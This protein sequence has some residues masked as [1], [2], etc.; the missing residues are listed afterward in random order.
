MKKL[1]HICATAMMALLLT[2]GCTWT[3]QDTGTA[4]GAV[5]GG[6]VGSAITG[7]SAVGTIG[8]AVAGGF[9]GN[10]VSQ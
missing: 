4:V 7:G 10:R 9:I 3:K 2:S 6:I 5:G 1:I 8:G